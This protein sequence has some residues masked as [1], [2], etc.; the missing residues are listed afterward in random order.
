[1]WLTRLAVRRPVTV[2]MVL[3]SVLVLGAISLHRLPLNFLPNAELPF[4]GVLIPYPNGI[5]GQVEKEI[6]RPVEEVLATMG[7]VKQVFSQSDAEQSFVGVEF[8]WGRNV[9]LLRLEVKEKLDQIRPD[10]PA[11][12]RDIMLFTFN[13]NDIPIVEGR[14]SAKDHDLSGSYDLIEHRIVNRLQRVPGVGR[15]ML[16]GVEPAEVSV[17]L[18]LDKIKEH[19]IDVGRLFNQLSAS[20]FNLT[21]GHVTK[22]GLRY[23]LRS[24]GSLHSLDDIRNLPVDD[25]GLRL[26]DVADVVYAEPALTYGRFLNRE[27][28]VAF[29]VQ[30]ASGANTVEV[31][32]AI[33]KELGRINR[34]PALEGIDALLFFDQGEQITNSLNGLLLS[35]LIGGVLAVLVLYFFLL[36]IGTTLIVSLAIPISIIGTACFLY[37][38]GRSLNVLS[39]MGLML[40]VGM[41]IDNAV[42][43]LESIYRRMGQGEDPVS[44][45]VNGTRDVGKPVVSAT[46]TSIIV[47]APVIFGPKNELT[48]WLAEVGVTIT[49]TLLLSLL[50]SLTLIPLL[51]SHILKGGRQSVARNPLVE[52]WGGIYER[53]L[54]W[55]AIRH[56]WITGIPIALGVLLFTVALV[57]VTKFKPDPLGERGIRQEY[58]QINYDFSDN[59]NYHRTK[60][61]VQTVQDSLWKVK[62]DLGA[63]YIYCFYQDNHAQTRLYFKDKAL[64]EKRLKE[65][66]KQV[67]EAL[68]TMAGVTFRLGD[69][70]GK[71]TG[72]KRFSVTVWGEDSEELND[73]ASEVKRRLSLVTDVHDVSTDMERGAEEVQVRIDP[74]RARQLGISPG[75][76]ARVMAVT[77]RGVQLPRVHADNREIDLWVSLDP[78]D[79][80]NI[81]NLKELMVGSTGGREITLDQVASTVMGRGA[82]RITRHN[83]KTAVE[84]RGNYEGKDFDAVLKEVR[85][86]MET[87]HFPPG[88]GW[89]FG[90]RIQEAQEQ[91]GQMG[92]DVL[93]ALIC[94]YMVMASLFESLV[95]PGTV[96]FCI[97]FASLGVIWFMIATNT[98]FNLMAMIGMVILVG[99]VVNNGIVLVA[100][101]NQLRREGCSLDEALVQGGRERFRPIMM[102]ATTTILGLI[103]LALGGSHVGDLDLYPMARALIGGLAS[104]TLLTLVMLPVYYQ[105]TERIRR[106]LARLFPGLARLLARLRARLRRRPAGA[107]LPDATP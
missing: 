23:S 25:R 50:V 45:T 19:R 44:A 38:T 57:A 71:G 98:P 2:V 14:I 97:P 94:V 93:L 106:R 77:F 78:A 12:V 99:V 80:T 104:S 67:R 35:G 72:A 96:M 29:I 21:V 82:D 62:D 66:R 4:I 34:D 89:N 31:V 15:V 63:E 60:E 59:L 33:K 86:T 27:P 18:K 9:D 3:V 41:L 100:H 81:E 61:Y 65:L 17:Y 105:L 11:D 30:K 10:L 20:N 92:I 95:H 69:D 22:D 70:E 40:G 24:V 107:A 47:F 37:L 64:S 74:V 75:D 43:V 83:R 103:P 68:P 36:R 54:R 46:L 88:Y 13:T 73:M 49:V 102:T 90:T 79:R 58:L 84:V 91:Q 1:M 56:P 76:V 5:P 6:T 85:A 52:R 42:V 8:N 87:M 32:D 39:M 16:D 55:T 48:T 26:R 101:I 51:T 53:V 7:G 28:A